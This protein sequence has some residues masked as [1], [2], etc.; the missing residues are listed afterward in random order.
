MF[1]GSPALRTARSA[2]AIW[3]A[4]RFR[5]VMLA[6]VDFAMLIS[7][8]PTPHPRSATFVPGPSPSIPATPSS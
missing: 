7:G 1:P 5:P 8:P 4:F 2:L 3:F 6:P